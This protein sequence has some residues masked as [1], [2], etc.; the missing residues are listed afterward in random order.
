[1]LDDKMI[2]MI[3]NTIG[4]INYAGLHRVVGT[5]DMINNTELMDVVNGLVEKANEANELA[6]KLNNKIISVKLYDFLLTELGFNTD[7]KYLNSIQSHLDSIQLKLKENAKLENEVIEKG[8]FIDELRE[9]TEAYKYYLKYYDDEEGYSLILID[10]EPGILI[11]G[12][13]AEG[14]YKLVDWYRKKTKDE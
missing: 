4:D 13:S 14:E 11:S 8:N 12:Y 1:M 2:K 5:Y 10:G 3:D 9:E 7:C 6:D